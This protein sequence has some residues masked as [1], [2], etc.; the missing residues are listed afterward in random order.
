[1]DSLKSP[2]R[3]AQSRLGTG[4]QIVG[5][6]QSTELDIAY[7]DSILAHEIYLSPAVVVILKDIKRKLLKYDYDEFIQEVRKEETK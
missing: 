2:T 6:E 4:G 1:M 3:H 5:A 7:L